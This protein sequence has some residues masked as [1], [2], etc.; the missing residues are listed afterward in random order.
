MTKNTIETI[1]NNIVPTPSVYKVEHFQGDVGYWSA[2]HPVW[3]SGLYQERKDKFSCTP[4][5]TK[6]EVEK[7]LAQALSSKKD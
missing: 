5:Y 1:I 6:D 2:D 4:L 7:I 3:Q